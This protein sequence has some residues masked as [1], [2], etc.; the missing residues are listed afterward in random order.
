MRTI[1]LADPILGQN[2]KY[3]YFYKILN[4]INN[5]F[6]YGVHETFNI[7]DFYKGS[8]KSINNA[9]KK[10]GIDN[11]EKYIIKFFEDKNKMYDYESKTVNIDLVNDS[12]CYN[13]TVGGKIPP[14][15][16]GIKTLKLVNNELVGV[17][18]GNI[19]IKKENKCIKINGEY[20]DQYIKDG[21]TRGRLF[22]NPN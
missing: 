22:S 5:K 14:N 21:W 13:E 15:R 12:N 18:K 9:Y 3:Y 16:L 4:K 19:W 11:F 7:N 20:L 2:N 8:G 1:F 10:Y 17:S 6:Y